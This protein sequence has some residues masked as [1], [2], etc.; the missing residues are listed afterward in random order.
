M[1]D[2][3]PEVARTEGDVLQ[4]LKGIPNR[5][6]SIEDVEELPEI[7]PKDVDQ[8]G[9]Q[10]SASVLFRGHERHVGDDA[11]HTL[12]EGVDDRLLRRICLDEHQPCPN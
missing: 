3:R 6:G 12:V 2:L 11:L 9:E 7:Q 10:L 1:R 8:I 4:R 5:I